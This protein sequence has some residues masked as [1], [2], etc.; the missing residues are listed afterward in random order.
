MAYILV[1]LLTSRGLVKL[2]TWWWRVQGWSFVRNWSNSLYS[3]SPLLQLSCSR[4]PGIISGELITHS[5]FSGRQLGSSMSFDSFLS[6]ISYYDDRCAW[7]KTLGAYW[8]LIRLNVAALPHLALDHRY[9]G[10]HT[11]VLVYHSLSIPRPCFDCFEVYLVVRSTSSSEQSTAWGSYAIHRTAFKDTRWRVS[12]S[13]TAAS[14]DLSALRWLVQVHGF[15]MPWALTYT[16]IVQALERNF[17][18]CSK[19]SF[20]QISPATVY[21]G[22]E[23]ISNWRILQV[24]HHFDWF[25]SGKLQYSLHH[26]D[27]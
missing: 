13:T 25:L 22:S 8:P 1:R 21:Q 15:T 27:D 12:C 14:Q 19:G 10:Y 24:H 4:V 23:D 20:L 7:R 2:R 6:L 26:F 16:F 11:A 3:S 18:F 5:W 9:H 17:S